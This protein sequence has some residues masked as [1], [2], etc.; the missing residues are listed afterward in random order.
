MRESILDRTQRAFGHEHS[1]TL[2]DQESLAEFLIESDNLDRGIELLEI[3]HAVF[4]RQASPDV[5][6]IV[7]SMSRLAAAYRASG[8]KQR[9]LE[10]SRQAVTM[11][12]EK[13]DS[14]DETTPRLKDNLAAALHNAGRNEEALILAEQVLTVRRRL[15]PENDPATLAT[16]V[17]HASILDGLGQ[18]EQGGEFWRAWPRFASGCSE[19]GIRTRLV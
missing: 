15:S 7:V 14:T 3:R 13:L 16:M 17:I 10:I 4:L 5:R 2:A 19:N 1:A 18:K 6:A 8:D 9:A 11:S 12:E